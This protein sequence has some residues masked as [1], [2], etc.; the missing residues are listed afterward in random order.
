VGAFTIKPIYVLLFA[1]IFIGGTLFA[2]ATLQFTAN[3]EFTAALVTVLR[4]V[5]KSVA[6]RQLIVIAAASLLVRFGLNN[7]LKFLTR[8]SSSPVQWDKTKLFYVLREVYQPLELL[9]FI[10]GLCTIADSFVPQL[11]GVP[12]V[13]ARA[14]A[15]RHHLL[16]PA[17]GRRAAA[18]G[19]RQAGQP[20]GPMLAP[21]EALRLA[22]PSPCLNNRQRHPR[23]LTRA[24]APARRRR[25]PWPTWCA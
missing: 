21:G 18:Q 2:S 4:R 1:L 24:R 6:F 23:P 9:L 22:G 17:A 12:K 13:R 25:A 16:A 3:M 7:V 14:A 20:A 19:R 8:F 10:A 15:P 11:I 5:A